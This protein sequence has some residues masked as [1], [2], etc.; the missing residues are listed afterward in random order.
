MHEARHELMNTS[1]LT[2]IERARTSVE[3]IITSRYL[4]IQAVPTLSP[5]DFAQLT[6][7]QQEA[8]RWMAEENERGNRMRVG[9]HMCLSAAIVA[10]QTAEKLM[11]DFPDLPPQ[12][13]TQA[14]LK[15]SEDAMVAS[16]AARHAA[17]VLS[18][19]E[20]PETE[21]FFESSQL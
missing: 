2:V 11:H 17:A 10:L 18:G 3:D 4:G 15:C 20:I 14:L 5:S 9:L 7:A 21:S 12:L 13:R 19:E 6:P 8:E 1:D 16:D